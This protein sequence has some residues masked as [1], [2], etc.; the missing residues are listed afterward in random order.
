[1]RH[2]YSLTGELGAPFRLCG[3]AQHRRG[4][5]SH[6]AGAGCALNIRERIRSFLERLQDVPCFRR[7]NFRRARQAEGATSEKFGISQWPCDFYRM[8]E[9]CTRYL[10]VTG[11]PLRLAKSGEQ[12][13]A[14]VLAG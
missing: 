6:D 11:L 12:I 1:V 14:S 2:R 7:N 9:R 4:Q 13:E 8:L 5:A 3:I 10:N